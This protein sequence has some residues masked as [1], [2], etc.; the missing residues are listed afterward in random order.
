MNPS[1]TRGIFTSTREQLVVLSLS[2]VPSLILPPGRSFV[3]RR[4]VTRALLPRTLS[5][6]HRA[7][8]VAFAA[9]SFKWMEQIKNE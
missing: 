4:R 8:T 2:L 9:N 1:K 5:T 3:H 7:S 6:A